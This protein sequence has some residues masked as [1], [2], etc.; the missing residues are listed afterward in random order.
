MLLGTFG[1][2]LMLLAGSTIPLPV[3]Q[4]VMTAFSTAMVTNDAE[5]VDG[6]SLT[7]TLSKEQ[8]DF[9]L[10]SDGTFAPFTRVVIA[11]ILG[12]DPEVL[13]DGWV[14]H[15]E[16]S[17]SD[18]AGMSTLTIIGRDMSAKLDLEEKNKP[19][20]ARSDALIARE[21]LLPLMTY[22]VIPTVTDTTDFPI[23]MLR[24][25]FQHET[26]FQFLKRIARRNGFVTYFEPVSVGV[27]KAYWGPKIRGGLP[28]PSLAV[29]MG[30]DDTAKSISF[31]N[32]ALA[33]VT[34]AGT[35]IDP[36]LHQSLPIPQ[37]PS[38]RIPPFS[39]SPATAY[40]TTLMR[41]TAN[42]SPATS[43]IE[44]LAAG[45]NAPDAVDAQGECE[46]ARYG[47]I[48]RARALVGVRGVGKTYDGIYYVSKVEHRIAVGK[49]DQ[50]FSL[51]REGT[52]ALLPVVVP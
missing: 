48:L 17:A 12:I 22:G 51:K 34:P 46:T 24:T 2:R 43:A 10:I 8:L 7:F 28:Q 3:S 47:N 29:N 15:Q 20:T 13:I 16:L 1:I 52:G 30:P 41:D 14:T 42:K 27:S 37:L 5:N 32:D 44:M 36:F 45:T 18:R 49:Y 31:T 50:R 9:G 21:L 39:S 38:L 6:F 35:F 4:D 19:F 11:V 33:P 25:P 26:A 23:P 40:R